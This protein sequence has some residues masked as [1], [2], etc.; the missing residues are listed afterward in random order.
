MTK[1]KFGLHLNQETGLRWVGSILHVLYV[2][3]LKQ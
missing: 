2:I 3:N 1:K